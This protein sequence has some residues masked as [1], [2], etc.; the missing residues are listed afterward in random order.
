MSITGFTLARSFAI[1]SG[2]SSET[3][4]PAFLSASSALSAAPREAWRWNTVASAA[5]SLT[6]FFSSALMPSQVLRLISSACGL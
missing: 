1:S 2:G 4:M 5:A 6:I 3:V